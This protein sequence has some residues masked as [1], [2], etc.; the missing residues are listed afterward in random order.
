MDCILQIHLGMARSLLRA[1]VILRHAH[2]TR[3]AVHAR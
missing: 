1:A 2:H 3:R